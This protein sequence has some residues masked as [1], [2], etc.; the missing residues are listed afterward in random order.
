MKFN[1][2]DIVECVDCESLHEIQLGA[3]YRVVSRYAPGDEISVVSIWG[4][5]ITG[6]WQS[7]RFKLSKRAGADSTPSKP[8]V[9]WLVKGTG[10]STYEHHDEDLA[11]KEAARL[12]R[13]F[14]G[15]TFHV[16]AP[17]VA[18]CKSDMQITDLTEYARNGESNEVPF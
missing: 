9:F 13:E 16:M 11:R 18:Y 4:S 15:E 14:P 6:P 5:A 10:P 8:R 12:A 7:Y 2:G 17:V 1:L 3:Q